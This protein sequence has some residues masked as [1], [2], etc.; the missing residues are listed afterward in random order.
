MKLPKITTATWWKTFFWL[1]VIAT[2]FFLY[3]ISSYVLRG[4]AQN[5]WSF[6]VIV[7]YI[8]LLVD[9]FNVVALYSFAYRRKLFPQTFWIYY[10]LFALIMQFY[11]FVPLVAQIISSMG[12]V[13]NSPGT[14]AM[15][16]LGAVSQSLSNLVA[17]FFV[18][19][20]LY[21]LA[22]GEVDYVKKH[23]KKAK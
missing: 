20:A 21:Q 12:K 3:S 8:S 11:F 10:F 15:M 18:F 16:A 17:K 23:D 22:I 19:Y 9:I 5:M 6:D 2:V 14:L 1:N 13:S 4:I 7:A